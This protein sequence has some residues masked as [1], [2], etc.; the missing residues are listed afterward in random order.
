MS[1]EERLRA[2]EAE[3]AELRKALRRVAVRDAWTAYHE[4]LCC[5][6][7]WRAGY[8]EEHRKSCFARPEGVTG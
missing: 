4:C 2:A 5:G 6:L 8:P 3:N 7:Q 1:T